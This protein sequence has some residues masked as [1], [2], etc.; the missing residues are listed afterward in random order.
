[1]II[2]VYLPIILVDFAALTAY[3]WG[4]QLY[5]SL[6]DTLILS[7]FSI[8]MLLLNFRFIKGEITLEEERLA[9]QLDELSRE[10]DIIK[11]RDCSLSSLG[12]TKRDK[13]ASQSSK[14]LIVRAGGALEDINAS[15]HASV[16]RLS[17]LSH[18]TIREA[19]EAEEIETIADPD[20]DMSNSLENQDKSFVDLQ[21][22]KDICSP[23]I[24]IEDGDFNTNDILGDVTINE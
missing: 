15:D 24:D 5:I 11:L 22:S 7:L 16:G 6:A 4:S 10:D 9:T 14:A 23:P 3:P 17:R 18:G 20:V 13:G 21:G 2:L 19:D 1:V 8:L 12:S